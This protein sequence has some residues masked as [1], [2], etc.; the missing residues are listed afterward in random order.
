MRLVQDILE[1]DPKLLEYLKEGPRKKVERVQKQLSISKALLPDP[2]TTAT[3][4]ELMH[5]L[6]VAETELSF[7]DSVQGKKYTSQISTGTSSFKDPLIHPTI[8]ST[9]PPSTILEFE[10]LLAKLQHDC[11]QDQATDRTIQLKL[12]SKIAEK[13]KDSLVCVCCIGR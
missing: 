1:D 4:E 13:H 5:D 10:S 8:R 3:C 7:Y 12:K 11:K 6:D 9:R 2:Y